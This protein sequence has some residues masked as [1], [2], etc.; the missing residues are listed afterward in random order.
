MDKSSCISRWDRYLSTTYQ[1]FIRWFAICQHK[2]TWHYS[3]LFTFLHY[4][5]QSASAAIQ[6]I[7]SKLFR[8]V[9]EQTIIFEMHSRQSTIL[10]IFDS[11]T[12]GKAYS[13]VHYLFHKMHLTMTTMTNRC[14]YP[15]PFIGRKLCLPIWNNCVSD[16]QTDMWIMI[17]VI[18]TS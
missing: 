7:N 13:I 18:T 15:P 1:W 12:N 4:K 11:T 5:V 2:S 6:S 3:K 17:E 10:S 16:E 8:Y 14:I 9:A